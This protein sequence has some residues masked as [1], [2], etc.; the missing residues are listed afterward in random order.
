ALADADEMHRQSE[1]FSNRYQDS[2]TGRPVE[3]GHDQS[4]DACGLAEYL[5]LAE[6]VLTNCRV[7]HKQHRV[8]SSGLNLT[9]DAHHFFQLAH[10]LGA[11]LKPAGGIDQHDLRAFALRGGDGIKCKAGRI[12]AWL[13][14]D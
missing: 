4:S 10:Q 8:W 6:C 7:E 3:L 2:T 14:R 13:A 12:T 9:H 11:I 1:F 5:D